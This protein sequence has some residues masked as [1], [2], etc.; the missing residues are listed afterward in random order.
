MKRRLFLATTLL[1]MVSLVLAGCGGSTSAPTATPLPIATGTPVPPPPSPVPPTSTVA[2]PTATGGAQPA[3]AQDLALIQQALTTTAALNSFH[4]IQ[5]VSGSMS[6]QARDIEG[7]YV[8]SEGL[9]VKG[10]V[11]DQQGSFLKVGTQNY[12]QDPGGNWVPWT[13]PTEIKPQTPQE[14]MGGTYTGMGGIAAISTFQNAG[15]PETIEGS[16]AQ[17]EHFVGTIPFNTIPG[18]P[19][20]IAAMKGLPP[21]GT[22]ALWIDPT[23]KI[24]Y[25]FELNVDTGPAMAVAAAQLATPGA[26]SG[27]T[28]GAGTPT[29]VPA[30]AA[31]LALKM[32]ITR[33]N[34]PT[35]QVPSPPSGTLGPAATAAATPTTAA[36]SGDAGPTLSGPTPTTVTMPLAATDGHH[37]AQTALVL[38]GP[39]HVD[40]TLSSPQDVVYFSFKTGLPASVG[41]WFYNPQDAVGQ[42]KVQLLDA[43]EKT[44]LNVDNLK[45]GDQT[46]LSSALMTPG[47]YL[48]KVTAAGL[49]TVPKT[50]VQVELVSLDLITP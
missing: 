2:P 37:T 24:V 8:A 36:I 15:A 14:I 11:G 44:E 46:S 38:T 39:T 3:S 19:P 16:S 45:P 42:L 29:A 27:A 41:L 12:K 34:D 1:V 5:S 28:P 30:Q 48:I 4:V 21:A 20:S 32:S 25:K 49:T 23:A 35:I 40:L 33:P 26:T 10:K 13:D 17:V 9:Y 7:D 31:T 47:V 43:S 22:I 18:I 50:P 6:P